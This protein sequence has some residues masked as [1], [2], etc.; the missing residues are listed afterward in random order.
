MGYILSTIVGSHHSHTITVDP[1]GINT[2]E[3]THCDV[4]YKGPATKIVDTGGK[5]SFIDKD[6][7][8]HSYIYRSFYTHA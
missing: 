5:L 7:R 2:I 6:G 1:S 8:E 4:Y 3:L